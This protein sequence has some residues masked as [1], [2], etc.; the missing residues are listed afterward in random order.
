MHETTGTSGDANSRDPRTGG[1]N[2]NKRDINSSNTNNS[3]RD[4]FNIL[5][6]A[7]LGLVS[8]FVKE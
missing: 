8:G 2:I 3:S 4:H 7:V 6:A 1:N 5:H